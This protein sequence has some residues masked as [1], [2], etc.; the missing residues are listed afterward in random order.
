MGHLVKPDGTIKAGIARMTVEEFLKLNANTQSYWDHWRF[1]KDDEPKDAW[2][3]SERARKDAEQDLKMFS[4]LI[5]GFE[6][7]TGVPKVGEWIKGY[8]GKMTRFTHA[9]DDGIQTG[10]GQG[11]FYLLGRHGAS[12]SG[13]LDSSVPYDLLEPTEE[14]ENG[15]F[16]RFH[17]YSGAHRGV[18]Y[19][20]PCKVW[21][22]K[23]IDKI[24]DVKR[25][26]KWE[27]PIVEVTESVRD[28]ALGV[29]PPLEWDRT[30]GF[31]AMGEAYS[32]EGTVPTYYC[33]MEINGKQYCTIGTV[34]KAKESY[35]KFI[36]G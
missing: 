34:D 11:S 14:R 24:Q 8:D 26:P 6:E 23:T 35:A 3:Q 20:H 30:T 16:W 2:M 31:F 25:V 10:G 17:K 4:D 13:G 21:K 19:I 29:L 15:M 5:D 12:Y 1:R 9:W 32:H 18:N 36:K 28:Y 33:F 27:Y 7:Y 22:L